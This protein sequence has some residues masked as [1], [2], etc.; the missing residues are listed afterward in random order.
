MRGGVLLARISHGVAAQQRRGVAPPSAGRGAAGLSEASV[1]LDEVV[2]SVGAVLEVADEVLG[3]VLLDLAAAGG[4]AE[5]Y[6]GDGVGVT[7]HDG[8]GVDGVDGQDG[9]D[10]AD[11]ISPE[12]EYV[13]VCPQVRGSYKETLVLLNG[14]YLA[15]LD[16]GSKDRLAQLLENVMYRTTDGR[17]VR[18]SIVNGEIECL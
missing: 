13:E 18:F 1:Q 16:G 15:F 2:T 4:S 14:V 3:E 17:N 5:G 8:D 7:G 12:I 9:E 6:R 11:G 10:G